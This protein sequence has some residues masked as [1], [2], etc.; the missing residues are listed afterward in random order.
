[1]VSEMKWPKERLK[2]IVSGAHGQKYTDVE[3]LTETGAARLRF[4][5][6][7][8]MAGNPQ[9]R[10][11]LYGRVVRLTPLVDQIKEIKHVQ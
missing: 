5:L 9:F 2:A 7:K 6:Y 4:A 8:Y 11:T 10:I 3:C 1:M